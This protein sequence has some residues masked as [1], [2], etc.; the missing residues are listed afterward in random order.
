MGELPITRL[1]IPT[2]RLPHA[3]LDDPILFLH[4][5]GNKLFK[6]N[7]SYF[8][9]ERRLVNFNF[10]AY[11]GANRYNNSFVQRSRQLV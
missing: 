1:Q 5:I 3:V 2:N 9:L 7:K 8:S 11:V 6:L 4:V 10:L